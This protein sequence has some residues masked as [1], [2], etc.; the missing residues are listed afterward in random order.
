VTWIVLTVTLTVKQSYCGEWKDLGSV[1]LGFESGVALSR[2][3]TD[4]STCG[5]RGGGRL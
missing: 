1:D 5:R 4:H 2:G 3:L